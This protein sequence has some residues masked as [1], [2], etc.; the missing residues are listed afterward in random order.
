VVCR[1]EVMVNG[2]C[3]RLRQNKANL[4]AR[5]QTGAGRGSHRRSSRSGVL[6]QTNPICGRWAG[7]TIAKAGG[8]DAATRGRKRAKQSQSPPERRGNDSAIPPSSAGAGDSEEQSQ[9]REPRREVAA[10]PCRP[11]ALSLAPSGCDRVHCPAPAIRRFLDAQKLQKCI[12]I[13]RGLQKCYK[14][15]SGLLSRCSLQRLL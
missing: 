7:K 6:R 1:K 13:R 8:L 4:P 9:F 11:C 3:N 15:T 14:A 5:P 10:I 2:T 12:S